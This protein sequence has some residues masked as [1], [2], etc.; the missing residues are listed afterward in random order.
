MSTLQEINNIFDTLKK[1]MSVQNSYMKSG[2][3]E[4]Q[5]LLNL[6]QDEI[7]RVTNLMRDN[8]TIE[9]QENE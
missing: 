1:V 7:L 8:Q 6:L 5:Q 4:I 9:N 2:G 3:N